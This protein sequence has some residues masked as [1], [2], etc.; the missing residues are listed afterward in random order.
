MRSVGWTAAVL[1]LLSA[2]TRV[3]DRPLK[4]G[5][6]PWAG[7]EPLYL[8][9]QLELYPPRSIHLVEFTST[10]QLARAFR[11]G[12]IDA[13]TV[14]LLEALRFEN[15]G[16]RPQVVLMLDSSNSAD[17]LIARAE[18]E[19]IS[20]LK[21][22]RVAHA[23]VASS[24]YLLARLAERGGLEPGDLREQILS[25]A[26]Q[27]TALK[28]GRV[29]AVLTSGP[30][31][32]RL[33]A[34]GAMRQLFDSSQLPGEFVDVLVVRQEALETWPR[35]VDT[36]LRGWFAALAHY[37][38]EPDSA[39]QHMA[40]RLG[41][42]AERFQRTLDGIQLAGVHEQRLHLMGHKPRLQEMIRQLGTTMVRNQL[43]TEPPDSV[44]LLNAEPLARVLP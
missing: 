12:V 31:C 29:D 17:C 20:G 15:M 39:S 8:A 1:L 23:G 42:D 2:C 14:P 44:G 30:H 16:Q 10:H 27:E 5:T 38:R 6:Y 19:S 40:P 41:L 22:K 36:L 21:G 9:R 25:E 24:N 43:L 13:A 32:A 3:P 28:R 7:S 33:L 4:V 18:V 37:Q 26:A 11:N 34:G 35:Q